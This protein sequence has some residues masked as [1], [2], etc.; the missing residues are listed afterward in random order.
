M[1]I[2]ATKSKLNLHWQS[3]Q[4]FL[5]RGLQPRGV[6][7]NTLYSGKCSQFKNPEGVSEI[8]ANILPSIRMMSDLNLQVRRQYLIGL[9]EPL[10]VGKP[11]RRTGACSGKC[12]G[13]PGRQASY[14]ADW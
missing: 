9:K 13:N 8:N 5:V 12:M 4:A 14:P 11:G 7:F 1:E 6:L 10:N 2:S 3:Y